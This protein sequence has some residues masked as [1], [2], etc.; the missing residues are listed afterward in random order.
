MTNI[1]DIIKTLVHTE[2]GTR[3][4]EKG[5]YQFIVAKTATKIDIARAIEKM[6]KVKV[7]DVNTIIVRGKMK[8]VRR[9]I[10]KQ[11]DWK[12]AFVQL[13]EGQKIEI[14]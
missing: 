9:E 3:L 10:G 7:T 8:R 6:Y 13:Q 2:K 5:C 12:K 11:P 1:F 4:E 14:K